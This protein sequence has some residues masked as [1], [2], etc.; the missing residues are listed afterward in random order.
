MTDKPPADSADRTA[1]GERKPRRVSAAER[2]DGNYTP[3]EVHAEGKG[4]PIPAFQP[5]P[6]ASRDEPAASA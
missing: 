6:E 5:W 1:D 4:G 2:Q 3:R